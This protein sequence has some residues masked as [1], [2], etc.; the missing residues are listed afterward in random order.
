MIRHI[1]QCIFVFL[2]FFFYNFVHFIFSITAIDD[3]EV[4]ASP[5]VLVIALCSGCNERGNCNFT[6]TQISE[7]EQFKRASCDCKTGYT[8]FLCSFFITTPVKKKTYFLFFYKYE[9]KRLFH[10]TLIF[11]VI[12]RIFFLVIRWWLWTWGRWL[13][14]GPVSPW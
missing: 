7:T 3:Y 13:C 10:L 11:L 4:E 5:L 9:K 8:G 12:R 6:T 14:S 2:F 1:N